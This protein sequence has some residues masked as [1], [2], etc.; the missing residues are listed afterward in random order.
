SRIGFSGVK[1]ISHRSFD[2]N[3]DIAGVAAIQNLTG[4]QMRR[5]IGAFAEAADGAQQ[6]VLYF[7]GH[8]I[9]VSGQNYLIPVDAELKHIKRVASETISL[10][11]VLDAVGAA[12]ELQLVIL[13]ACRNNPFRARLFPGRDSGGGLRAVEPPGGVL[14]AYAAKHGH[15]ARDGVNE[16]SP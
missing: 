16:N 13:D 2:V 11:E 5:A 8:G 12:K 6:A 14:V 3:F 1:S 7:A 9:E 15:I 4:D 10:M